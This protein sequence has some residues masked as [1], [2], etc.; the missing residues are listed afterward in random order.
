MTI[1]VVGGGVLGMMHALEARRLGHDVVHLERESGSR[2]AS[3][4][5]FG[6]IWVSGRAPGP[7]PELARRARI[8][9]D[10]IASQVPGV[11]LRPNGSLTPATDDAELQL[12]KEAAARPDAN[13][14]GCE[15]LDQA[16]AR[17]VNPAWRSRLSFPCA[18]AP[19]PTCETIT[20]RDRAA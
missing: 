19:P 8:R 20:P 2:R 12:L 16:A 9:W 1:V 15:L 11:G 5:N 7:E 13:L 18:R 4:R 6:L 10:E 14:R 3:V 17:S